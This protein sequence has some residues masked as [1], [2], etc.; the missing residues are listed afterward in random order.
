MPQAQHYDIIEIKE[1]WAKERELIEG[2]AKPRKGGGTK[3][4]RHGVKD[5]TSQRYRTH[6]WRMANALTQMSKER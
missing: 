5:L 4:G 1:A 3:E 2:E 6:E